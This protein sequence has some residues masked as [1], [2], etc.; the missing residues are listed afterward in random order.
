GPVVLARPAT[1]KARYARGT[2]VLPFVAVRDYLPTDRAARPADYPLGALLANGLQVAEIRHGPARLYDLM[3]QPPARTFTR[4]TWQLGDY[5]KETDFG[6]RQTC[7]IRIP[8]R[9]FWQFHLKRGNAATAGIVVAHPEKD[10]VTR[11]LASVGWWAETE[12]GSIPLEAGFHHLEIQY[13]CFYNTQNGLEI[14]IE[15]PGFPRQPLPDS[16]LY[17][18]P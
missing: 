13:G 12:S 11:P 16:W 2:D 4:A 18:L 15:G 1:V 3:L 9:G 7:L 5:A 17:L 14:E 8:A 10:L 6:L